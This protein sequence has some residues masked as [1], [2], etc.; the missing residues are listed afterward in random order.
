[1]KCYCRE[2]L[3]T[4]EI[5]HPECE[6]WA[7][8]VSRES[9]TVE[10]AEAEERLD[11]LFGASLIVGY[12]GEPPVRKLMGAGW[13]LTSA[14]DEIIPVG[15]VAVIKTG[16]WIELPRGWE[17]Q[18]RAR[19]S[20]ASKGVLIANSPGTVDWNYRDEVGVILLNV[21]GAPYSVERSNRI[22]QLVFKRVFDDVRFEERTT[23]KREERDGGFGSTGR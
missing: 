16:L 10:S 9:I 7:A 8:G 2:S 19:S 22:A 4:N 12:K 11:Y 20:V 13:D 3:D 17:A 6:Q 21:S 1:M 5:R 15:K 18:V 23:L 14:S